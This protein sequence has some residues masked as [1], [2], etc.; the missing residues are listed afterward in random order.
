M[1]NVSRF[2]G[3]RKYVPL[4]QDV[5]GRMLDSVIGFARP[6]FFEKTAENADL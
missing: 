6:N 3:A 1:E 5:L 4:L 2:L